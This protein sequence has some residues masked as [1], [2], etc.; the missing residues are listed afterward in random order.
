[1]KPCMNGTGEESEA[2]ATENPR[3][4]EV[5]RVKHQRPVTYRRTTI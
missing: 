3:V 2:Q 1:M 5:E 4:E